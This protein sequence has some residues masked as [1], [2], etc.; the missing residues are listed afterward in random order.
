[1]S[2]EQHLVD[3]DN[4]K[5]EELKKLGM[6]CCPSSDHGL[7]SKK[8]IPKTTSCQ[9]SNSPPSTLVGHEEHSNYQ[10]LQG[11]IHPSRLHLLAQ[12]LVE[13]SSLPSSGTDSATTK[14]PQPSCPAL[15]GIL[16]GS[17][18]LN[19]RMRPSRKRKATKTTALEL[20]RRM[21]N[22][23]VSWEFKLLLLLV[24]TTSWAN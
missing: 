2:K 9:P 24:R 5:R 11:S 3:M 16:E 20:A 13:A 17:G 6:E 10:K 1:M 18:S 7:A 4:S 14:P 22:I 12:D 15:N 19:A 21:K 8:D 23:K